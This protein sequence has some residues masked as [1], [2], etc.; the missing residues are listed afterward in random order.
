MQSEVFVTLT[1]GQELRL[2]PQA[3]APMEH[4]QARRWLDDEF[5]RLECEPLRASGKVLLADKVL[6]IAQAAGERQF[7]DA[8]WG[9]QFAAAAVAALSRPV[10]RVDVPAMAVSF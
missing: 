6:T 1:P 9:Q 5:L 8:A 10:V 3:G 7:A 2:D 4:E